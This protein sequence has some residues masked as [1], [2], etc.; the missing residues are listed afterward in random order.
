MIFTKYRPVSGGSLGPA[1][2]SVPNAQAYWKSV[3]CQAFREANTFWYTLQDHLSSPS[4][5]V[6]DAQ[7]QPKYDLSC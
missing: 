1:T 7:F 4:F 2:P 6:V 5:G 3:A